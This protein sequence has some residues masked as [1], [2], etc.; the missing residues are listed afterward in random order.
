MRVVLPTSTA[1]NIP[2]PQFQA[3]TLAH[4][5][6]VSP[7]SIPFYQQVF[8]VYNNAAGVSAAQNILSNG[9]CGTFTALGTG[10]PCAL[11]FQATP[12]TLTLSLIHISEPTRQAEIS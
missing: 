6:S 5:Q 11:Q 3:A 2:S 8:S 4:L 12:S 7:L 10:V 1:V 9:G